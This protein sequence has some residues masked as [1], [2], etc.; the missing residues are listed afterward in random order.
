MKYIGFLLKHNFTFLKQVGKC[1]LLKL[2][3]SCVFKS[4]FL[5]IFLIQLSF[6]K[7][8]HLFNT[9]RNGFFLF[10][11]QS[12]THV[13]H[14]N[15]LSVAIKSSQLW[16]ILVHLTDVGF[17]SQTDGVLGCEV[18]FLQVENHQGLCHS[19]CREAFCVCDLVSL[20]I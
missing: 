7:P 14:F 1:V 3:I 6:I 8:L 4:R 13:L 16:E 18:E 17:S 10:F 5:R 9:V 19:T 20:K 12:V 11:R 15:S 2:V